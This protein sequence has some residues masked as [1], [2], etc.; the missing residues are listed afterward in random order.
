MDLVCCSRIVPINL[1]RLKLR[2]A[3]SPR[4]NLK[5]HS[6][7]MFATP[8]CS[9]SRVIEVRTPTTPNSKPPSLNKMYLPSQPRDVVWLIWWALARRRSSTNEA[10]I[11][12]NSSTILNLYYFILYHWQQTIN[13][14]N[15]E[16]KKTYSAKSP[17][18]NR[19]NI[20]KLMATNFLTCLIKR[21][22]LLNF[23]NNKRLVSF[24]NFK[25]R[26][27]IYNILLLFAW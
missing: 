20:L 19:F 13:D 5:S 11:K 25:V 12:F 3:R 22:I 8:A 6:Q 26:V 7:T 15:I 24:L 18:K 4:T 2:T 9:S 21:L 10:N 17:K 1:R 14:S 16:P 23:S 27:S